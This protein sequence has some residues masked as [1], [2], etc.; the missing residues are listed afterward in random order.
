VMTGFRTLA[1]SL[2]IALGRLPWLGCQQPG[3]GRYQSA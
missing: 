1:A 3:A 2:E